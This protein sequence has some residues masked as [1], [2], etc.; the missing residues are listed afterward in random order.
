MVLTIEQEKNRQLLIDYNLQLELHNVQ[1]HA[2]RDLIT[3]AQRSCN[4]VYDTQSTP[5]HDVKICC[6]C[7]HHEFVK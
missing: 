3:A 7:N 6:I 2:L 1:A 4:H 5:Y